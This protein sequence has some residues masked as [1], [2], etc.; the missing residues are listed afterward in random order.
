MAA[1]NSVISSDAITQKKSNYPCNEIFSSQSLEEKRA[2][3]S[4]GGSE[5]N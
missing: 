1:S 5:K 3:L 2:V 4:G